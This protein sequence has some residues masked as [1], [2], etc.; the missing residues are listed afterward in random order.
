MFSLWSL[1]I[2]RAAIH[3]AIYLSIFQ[4]HLLVLTVTRE[5][6]LALTERNRKSNAWLG[7]LWQ[8]YGLQV[9]DLP[10]HNCAGWMQSF[11]KQLEVTPRFRQTEMNVMLNNDAVC[12]ASVST[13]H[14]LDHDSFGAC[15]SRCGNSYLQHA[16][17][18]VMLSEIAGNATWPCFARGTT[19]AHHHLLFCHLNFLY[20]HM[21][22]WCQQLLLRVCLCCALDSASILSS[23]V[24]YTSLL[25]CV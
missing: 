1:E 24:F 25:K 4:T 13:D 14:D 21:F 19:L 7:P 16:V 6:A 20:S 9:S 12:S 17:H 11:C 23:L 5:L 2:T 18:E 8:I 3:R 15:V 22:L 10:P